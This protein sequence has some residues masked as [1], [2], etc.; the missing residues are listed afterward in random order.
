[1]SKNNN[2]LLGKL[3]WDY[4]KVNHQLSKSDCI[5][6]LG[7]QDFKPAE[8]GIQLLN[9]GWAPLIIFSGGFGQITKD[10]FD[11]P[12]AEKYFDLALSHGI[13]KEQIFV[14]NKS[15]N[16][17]ENIVFTK[18][19]LEKKR[20]FIK[21]AIFV[22]KPYMER[23]MLATVEK[24]WPEIDSIITS[25]PETFEEHKQQRSLHKLL[26]VLVGD[27]ERIILYSQKGYI[28]DQEV[29]KRILDAHHKLIERGY[30]SY[31]PNP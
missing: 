15:T 1:M 29:P 19:L 18:Q 9:E 22:H 27:T 7:S 21:K 26:H 13:S 28:T 4:H 12:E 20:M 25:P 2:D 6:V 5:I 11:K 24:V 16:T 31:L 17:S 14:E 8:Y 3:L 30:T 10:T 23:R